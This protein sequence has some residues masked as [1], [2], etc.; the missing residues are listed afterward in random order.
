[1]IIIFC[2]NTYSYM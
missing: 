1:M 2:E